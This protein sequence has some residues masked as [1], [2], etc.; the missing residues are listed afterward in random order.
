MEEGC[1]NVGDEE[2]EYAGEGN[3]YVKVPGSVPY[4]GVGFS[5]DTGHCD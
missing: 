5:A 1:E 4:F 3:A 2:A